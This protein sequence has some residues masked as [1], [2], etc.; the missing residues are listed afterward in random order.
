MQNCT[1]IQ[2]RK[3]M[4]INA[5]SFDTIA[6]AVF[7]PIYPVIADQII[8]YTGIIRGNC[9]DAGCG[10]GYLGSALARKTDLHLLFFD[11]SEEML[12]L[13]DRT[14]H[15]NGLQGRAELLPG[16]IGAIPLP[17][18]AVD[19]V[20]SRGSMFFWEDLPLAFGEIHRILAPG[21]KT[22]IGGGFGSLELQESIRRQMAER[23]QGGDQFGK[24]MRT[25]LGPEMRIRFEEALSTAGIH[26]FEILQDTEIGLWIIMYK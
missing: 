10:S 23:N 15:E 4:K 12:A 13:C 3:A 14:I 16:D 19:L 18:G 7:A 17:D 5:R 22:Y 24:K 11:Q 20:I 21:G 26:D 6:R 25:N 9:L 8:E 2:E 1:N